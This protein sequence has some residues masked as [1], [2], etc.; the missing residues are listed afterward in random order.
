[1]HCKSLYDFY[2]P[3]DRI[4]LRPMM[5]RDRA[6]LLTIDYAHCHHGTMRQ[7]AMRFKRG[8]HIVLNDTRVRAAAFTVHGTVRGQS[9]A[10]SCLLLGCSGG[11][12]DVWRALMRPARHLTK[13]MELSFGD[14]LTAN[15]V[16]RDET[17]H[18][19]LQFADATRLETR[20]EQLGHMPLPPYIVCHRHA[21][22][23]DRTD[24][25][26]LFA[27]HDGSVAAPTAGLHITPA[28]IRSWRRRGVRVSYVT[29]HVGVGTFMPMRGDDIHQ[30]HLHAE[31]GEVRACVARALN[32]TRRRGGRIIA[33]GTTALRLLE[34]A[35]DASEHIHPFRSET[36]LFIK[37]HHRFRSAHYLL[38]NFHLPSSSLFVLVCAFAGAAAMRRAYA[39]AKVNGYRFYSYGDGCLLKRQ[40]T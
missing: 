25:Q 35:A 1:M 37:P 8:D 12:R 32:E 24:Y 33:V 31:W 15:F 22:E 34:S 23:R 13:G 14:S 9:R 10:F 7:L 39:L 6:R 30:H 26:T 21:D 27:R 40:Q 28:L 4:A 19:L 36:S 5:P 17:N 38:T 3:D 11:E 29:L 18:C 16:G 2:L 20:L